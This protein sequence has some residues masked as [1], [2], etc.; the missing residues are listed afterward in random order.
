MPEG[1]QESER[2]PE[3]IYTPTTKAA[4]EHDEPITFEQTVKLLGEERA[5][6]VKKLSIMIY[7]HCAQIAREKGI[8]IAD[9]KLEFGLDE[10]GKLVLADEVFTPDSSRFWDASLYSI[11]G[12]QKSMDKQPVRDWLKTQRISDTEPMPELPGELVEQTR[13]AYFE[14]APNIR[15]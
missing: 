15:F 4:D 12:A 8:I 14:I 3:P 2:L 10:N 9:T 1:L 11:G 5:A 13:A 6:K 7:E